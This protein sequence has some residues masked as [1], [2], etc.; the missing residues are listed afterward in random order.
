MSS[1][2]PLPF[3]GASFLFSFWRKNFACPVIRKILKIYK[4]LILET[5]ANSIP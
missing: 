5:P 4:S 1:L 2:L 3:K